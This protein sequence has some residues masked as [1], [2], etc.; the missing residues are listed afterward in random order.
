VFLDGGDSD[1]IEPWHF[2]PI[3]SGLH[4]GEV[5][6]RGADV[7]QHDD[8]RR[9]QH[10]KTLT[11]DQGATCDQQNKALLQTPHALPPFFPDRESAICSF[12]DRCKV[13]VAQVNAKLATHYS[14]P[15]GSLN[16]FW[17]S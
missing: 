12:A 9:F 7:D 3:V 15:S 8:D 17:N 2:N 10:F 4:R 5:R 13:S 1:A 16:W 6:D 11:G 14:T